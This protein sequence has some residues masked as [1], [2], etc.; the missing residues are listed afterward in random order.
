MPMD[1]PMDE[2]M[3]EPL[4]EL[5]DEP[6]DELPPM[7]MDEMNEPMHEPQ[8]DPLSLLAPHKPAEHR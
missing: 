2:L 1:E 3:D 8:I 4:P 7:P 6:M 5:S